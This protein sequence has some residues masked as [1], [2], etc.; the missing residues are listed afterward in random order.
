[1]MRRWGT[2]SLGRG[3]RVLAMLAGVPLIGLPLAGSG[4]AAQTGEFTVKLGMVRDLKAVFATVEGKDVTVARSRIAGTI[5]ALTVDEGSMVKAGQVIATVRDPKLPLR[6]AAVEAQIKAS[7]AQVTLAQQ[8]HERIRRLRETG[9]ATQARLDETISRLGVAEGQLAAQRAERQ[10]IEQQLKEGQVL[11]PSAG[12]VLKVH[13]TQG[14][15]VLGGE[16]IA[17]ITVDAYRLRILLPE[18]HARFI[19]KGDPVLVGRRGM[20][21]TDPDSSNGN[22]RKGKVV[23]VYPELDQGRVVA[24]VEVPGLGDFFVGERVLAYV[25]TGTR[26]TFLVPAGYVT[27]RMGA[28]FVRLKDGIEVV[29]QPGQVRGDMIEILSGLRAG[30]V[31]VKP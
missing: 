24:D 14:A 21:A 8:E 7:L 27:R 22:L 30:D 15:V 18:R 6:L 19:K 26:E 17:T 23:Q 28:D 12:R 9:A 5:E 11:S 1:M 10:V 3:L 2:G 20:A 25:S 16:K 4:A 29:V 13:V 31:L